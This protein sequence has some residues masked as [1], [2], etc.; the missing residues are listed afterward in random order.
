[1]SSIR[2]SVLALAVLAWRP[3]SA[4]AVH[5]SGAWQ[6]TLEAYVNVTASGR[7]CPMC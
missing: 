1:M 5:E 2:F 7:V 4:Q 6:S 3:A